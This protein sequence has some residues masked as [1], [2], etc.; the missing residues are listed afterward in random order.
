[1]INLKIFFHGIYFTEIQTK[2]YEV[3]DESYAITAIRRMMYRIAIKLANKNNCLAIAN[4]DS[5][6]QVSSQTIYSMN[7][8]EEVNNEKISII[9]P[10][11][12]FDKIDIIKIAKKLILMIYQLD[13]MMIVALFFHIKIQK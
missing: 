1:M 12:I 2:I 8:I 6:G 11:S 13:L 10:L 5:I 9:R 3:F 7:A 4:G